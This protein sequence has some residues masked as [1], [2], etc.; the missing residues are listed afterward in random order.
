MTVTLQ[1]MYVSGSLH[2]S[3]ALKAMHSLTQSSMHMNERNSLAMLATN[4]KAEDVPVSLI[5][6]AFRKQ[7]SRPH[8]FQLLQSVVCEG[9]KYYFTELFSQ[10]KQFNCLNSTEFNW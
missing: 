3:N 1:Y 9:I 7:S 8:T 2:W 10:D 4:G 5:A 6:Y